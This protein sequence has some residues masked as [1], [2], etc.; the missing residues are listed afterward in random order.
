[1]KG[2]LR[3]LVLLAIGLWA[4]C[5]AGELIKLTGKVVAM[6]QSSVDIR[7]NGLL[8]KFRH[9]DVILPAGMVLEDQVGK[10]ITFEVLSENVPQRPKP[11]KRR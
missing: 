7:A 3:L 4:E 1:M 11:K 8:K 6:D 10:T 2:S 9:Q 5:R